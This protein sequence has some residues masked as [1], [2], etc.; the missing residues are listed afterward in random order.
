ML[1]CLECREINRNQVINFSGLLWQMELR[2]IAFSSGHP[3][4]QLGHFQRS[5][6]TGGV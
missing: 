3:A 4:R 1:G 2:R 5:D 6:V